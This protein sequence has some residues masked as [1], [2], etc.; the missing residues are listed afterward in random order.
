MKPSKRA[1]TTHLVNEYPEFISCEYVNN[2]SDKNLFVSR[3]LFHTWT[4][5]L[6]ETSSLFGLTQYLTA[7]PLDT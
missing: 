7:L 5:S 1:P 6:V 2:H 3:I 4:I